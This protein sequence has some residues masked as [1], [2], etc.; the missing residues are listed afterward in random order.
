MA[1]G[2]K[3]EYP[4]LVIENLAVYETIVIMIQNNPQRIIIKNDS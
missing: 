1:K 3:R 4:I 2:K